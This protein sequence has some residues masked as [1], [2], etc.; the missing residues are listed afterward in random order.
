MP[1]EWPPV[2]PSDRQPDIAQDVFLE[3]PLEGATDLGTGG[4]FVC[5]SAEGYSGGG[6]WD[7]GFEPNNLWRPENIR[8]FAIQSRWHPSS[9]YLRAIQVVHWLRLI[10]RDYADLRNCL[11]EHFP[12]LTAFDC[13]A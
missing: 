7:L 6:V 13:D 4:P 12:V 5:E 3:F 9:R 1:E 10:Y 11:K 8:L 2:P